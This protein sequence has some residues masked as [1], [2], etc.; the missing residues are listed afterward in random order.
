MKSELIC[1]FLKIRPQL[2]LPSKAVCYRTFWVLQPNF[3]PV[4]STAWEKGTACFRR[5]CQALDAANGSFWNL[6]LVFA[7]SS[8]LSRLNLFFCSEGL[9]S[10]GICLCKKI[11]VSRACQTELWNREYWMII[12]D[13]A[14]S[15]SYMI[16]LLP[17]LLSPSPVSKLYRRKRIAW[18]REIRPQE[19]LVLYKSFNTFCYEV[20]FLLSLTWSIRPEKVLVLCQ[21]HVGQSADNSAVLPVFDDDGLLSDILL[22]VILLLSATKHTKPR[23]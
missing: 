19:S 20:T 4:G 14:F 11:V 18:W 23:K 1:Y 21:L 7:I 17:H 12:E 6:L 5:G 22:A 2:S 10:V 3:R 15:R 13:Q 9:L 16:W 8:K